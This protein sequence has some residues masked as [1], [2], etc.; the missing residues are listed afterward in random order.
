MLKEFKK[1]ALRGNVLDLA[2]GVIIGGAFGK[3]VSSLVDDIIMPPIRV[4]LSVS[5]VQN[6]AEW[7]VP[8][9]ELTAKQ[10]EALTSVE[11]AKAAG[12]Q[13]LNYGLFLNNVLTFLIVAFSVFLLVRQINRLSPPVQKTRDCPMCFSS[14]SAKARRCPNCTSEIVPA[15][16]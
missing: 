1:F 13:T 10:K 2:I 15:T 12:I 5:H 8:L 4:L 9:Q 16:S 14:I 6:A 3:I 7:F 11:A